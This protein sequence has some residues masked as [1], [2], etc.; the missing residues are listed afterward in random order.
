MDNHYLEMENLPQDPFM[1]LSYINTQLRD[2]YESLDELCASLG[3]DRCS[4]VARLAEAGFE[5]NRQLNKFW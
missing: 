5:Y 3:V 1:L 2:N 4:L